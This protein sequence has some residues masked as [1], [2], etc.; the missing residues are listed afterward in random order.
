MFSMWERKN[1]R[2]VELKNI[3]ILSFVVL[4][5]FFLFFRF[6]LPVNVDNLGGMH[7]WLSGSTIKFVNNWLEEGPERLNFTNYE[8]PRSI[9]FETLEEREP[10]LSYPT[11]ETMFV[12]VAARV[13]GRNSITISFLHKFQLIVFGI[14]AVLFSIFVYLFLAKTVK[15]KSGCQKIIIA[16]SVACLWALLPTCAY[17]LAN[18]YYSDQS[19]ILWSMSII[20]IEYIIRAF[21]VGGRKMQLL[22][23]LRSVLIYSGLLVDYYCWF[24]VL[25]LFVFELL[26]VFVTRKKGERRSEIISIFVWFGAPVILA[27]LTYYLQLIQTSGWMKVLASKFNERVAGRETDTLGIIISKIAENFTAAFSLNYIMAIYLGLVC[28]ITFVIGWIA[29]R[30]AKKSSLIVRNPGISIIVASILA[31]ITQV[32]FFKQ[33]SAIHEFSMIKVGWIIAFLPIIMAMV[34]CYVLRLPKEYKKDILGIKMGVFSLC[35]I[36]AFFVV[37]ALTG[38]PASTTEFTEKRVVEVRYD[39]ERIVAENTNFNDVLF[40][41]TEEILKNPPQQLAV[42]NKLLYKIEDISAIGDMF[43]NLSSNAVKILV[44]NNDKMLTNDQKKQLGC[45]REKPENVKRYEN[46]TYLLVELNNID[47]CKTK[48]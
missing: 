28:I 48:K 36:P 38:V 43:P 5:C 24:L 7:S 9:E 35:F 18:I 16:F 6:A 8:A 47:S 33:H 30:K 44:I 20:L 3:L 46:E 14:E 42:S 27:I 19:I 2:L 45:L 26:G 10:Y 22:K 31:I 17:Y 40:S 12:Y 34:A 23:V 21:N 25:F 37:V 39:F 1:G 11:G 41:Y 32:F 4:S 15:L 29:L 13:A